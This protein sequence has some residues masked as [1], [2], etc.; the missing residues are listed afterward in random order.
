MR[1]KTDR[2]KVQQQ[3]QM[4]KIFSNVAGIS[5]DKEESG[6]RLLEIDK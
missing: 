1:E 6:S 3:N 5:K 4:L 2:R